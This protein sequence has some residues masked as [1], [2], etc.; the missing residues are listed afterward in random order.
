MFVK[1]SLNMT[2]K[3]AIDVR[4][5]ILAYLESEQRPL[6]FISNNTDIPYGSVYSIFEQRTMELT[7]EKLDKVNQVLGTNFTLPENGTAKA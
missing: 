4:D 2:T 7:Q 3:K 1:Q 6:R 5:E